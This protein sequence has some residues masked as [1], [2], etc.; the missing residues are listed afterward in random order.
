[1]PGC[2]TL[3]PEQGQRSC[4]VVPARVGTQDEGPTC[5]RPKE[6]D[7]GTPRSEQTWPGLP[8]P[9]YKL[10]SRRSSGPWQRLRHPSV[11]YS[12]SVWRSC[13]CHRSRV[14]LWGTHRSTP[15][16][17]P[18]PIAVACGL[19]HAHCVDQ[20][21]AKWSGRVR[22]HQNSISVLCARAAYRWVENGTGPGSGQCWSVG[23]GRRTPPRQA[24][25]Q[26]RRHPP[27]CLIF[28][29]CARPPSLGETCTNGPP[30]GSG[31]APFLALLQDRH[32]WWP[33][34]KGTLKATGHQFTRLATLKCSNQW[35]FCQHPREGGAC[36]D[37]DELLGFGLCLLPAAFM[38]GGTTRF[39]RL[40]ARPLFGVH[41]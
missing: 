21:L 6:L 10:K 16:E 4:C 31:T 30:S 7:T 22:A 17:Y 14:P 8:A 32:Q 13:T 40:A 28:V 37:A 11:A 35:S 12:V 26:P 3:V 15:S 34:R 2:L 36:T 29:S 27:K 38:G 39:M 9:A 41:E 5:T 24:G 33:A 1:M 23:P 19:D 25:R 18:A 20:I